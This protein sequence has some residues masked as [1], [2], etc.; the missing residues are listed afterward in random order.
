MK[1]SRIF[2]F[3]AAAWLTAAPA[4]WAATATAEPAAKTDKVD[5]AE[6]PRIAQMR[7]RRLQQLDEKLHLTAEQK[8]RIQEIWNTAE[9]QARALHDDAAATARA[10]RTKR[11]EV[12]QATHQQVRGVLTPDQQ[13]IFDTMPRRAR[14][15]PA[16]GDAEGR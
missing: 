10:R 4:V 6:P 2:L 16:E 3:T 15:A 9:T 11:R 14:S 7:E 1:T 8:T 5:T 12:M 13:K